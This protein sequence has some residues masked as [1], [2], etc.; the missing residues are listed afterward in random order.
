[1]LGAGTCLAPVLRAGA[2]A[3]LDLSGEDRI[4][5][6]LAATHHQPIEP[7]FLTKLGRASKLWALGEKSLAH[8]HLIHCGLPAIESEEQAFRLFLADGLIAEGYPPAA[9]SKALGFDLPQGLCKYSPDQPRD[10]H[11][12]WTASAESSGGPGGFSLTYADETGD[13]GG[14]DV[15]ITYVSSSDPG[16]DREKDDPL[17]EER[18]AFGEETPEEDLRHGRPIDPMGPTAFPFAGGR[19]RR[20]PARPPARSRLIL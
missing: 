3:G 15:P 6:L 8:I 10:D 2:R 9:L 7:L 5:A 1:M 20:R 4:L 11:G 12:R 19:R 13:P 18:R 16:K 14:S 17:Y